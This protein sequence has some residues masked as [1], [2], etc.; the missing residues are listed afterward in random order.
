VFVGRKR[1]ERGSKGGLYIC[2]YHVEPN[3]CS[4]TRTVTTLR[5]EERSAHTQEPVHTG[6]YL[7]S[8]SLF[9]HLATSAMQG[10]KSE[11]KGRYISFSK[12]ERPFFSSH[13]T[14]AGDRGL[15]LQECLKRR[16]E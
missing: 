12:G 11:R 6:G 9:I 7:P 15:T 5:N 14:K 16:S 8:Q 10:G 1:C 3:S 4:H 2:T 13:S